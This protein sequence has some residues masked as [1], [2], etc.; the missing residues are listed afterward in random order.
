MYFT[1]NSKGYAVDPFISDQI[2]NDKLRDELISTIK[3]FRFAPR[4][5]AGKAVD[6]PGQYF[7]F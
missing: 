3:N 5:L 7:E 6:S 4:F 1:V 2:E